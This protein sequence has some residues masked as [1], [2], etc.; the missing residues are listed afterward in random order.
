MIHVQTKPGSPALLPRSCVI[1]YVPDVIKEIHNF[2]H[3]ETSLTRRPHI[4][5]T[6]QVKTEQVQPSLASH[7]F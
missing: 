6:V 2:S 3:T 7:E 4:D 5:N 1:L